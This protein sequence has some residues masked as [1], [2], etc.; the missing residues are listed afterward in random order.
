MPKLNVLNVSGQNV[1]EIELSDSIFGVE[2]N[3]HV[4]YEVVKNQLA[5]KRQGTQS[6]KTRAEVRGGGRKPWK[7]KGTG[8]A[9]QGSTRSVQWVGGG[10]AFAPKPRSYKYTLPKKVRRL[11]MKSALSS[12]VQNSEVIVL[13]ALNMDA[14]KTKEFA[15]ILNNINAAKKAL[16]VIAD[17]N[18][19][20]IKSARNIEGVQTA[21]VNTMNVYDILKYDSFIITT[22]AVKK[23][24]E[25]YA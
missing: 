8:R 25:V 11:A 9:R 23:V 22:D 15:Q 3:G 4:L 14:P 24:E 6:A 17:K 2:V 18:D 12:K 19:N 5:N 16:V 7:Q 1:G 20:V 21:L 10:V 13:D